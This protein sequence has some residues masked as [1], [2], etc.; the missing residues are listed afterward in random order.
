MVLSQPNANCGNIAFFLLGQRTERL[1][2]HVLCK[3]CARLV[4]SFAVKHE[5]VYHRDKWTLQ[6]N[7]VGI[8]TALWHVWSHL[9][10]EQWRRAWNLREIRRPYAAHYNQ[11]KVTAEQVSPLGAHPPVRTSALSAPISAHL[12]LR[13]CIFV[14]KAMKWCTSGMNLISEMLLCMYEVMYVSA[15]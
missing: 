2:C 11:S 12:S 9:Q 6:R 15:R 8:R 10:K 7:W 14:N 1:T 4:L 3:L 13:V 5:S